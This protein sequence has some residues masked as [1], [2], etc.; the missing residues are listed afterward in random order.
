ME[1]R[2]VLVDMSSETVT[3]SRVAILGGTGAL[4]FGLAKRLAAAGVPIVIGSRDA[5]R[6]A[7]AAKRLLED[8]PDAD[9]D[10]LT[11]PEAVSAADRLVVLAVPL[12]SQVATLK[13]VAEQLTEAHIVMDTTVP[14]AP[15]VGGRPT[16]TVGLWAGSAAQQAGANVPRGVGVVSGLHTLSAASLEDLSA[17]LDESTLICGDRKEHKDYVIDLLR[18]IEG[19]HVVDA[20]RLEMSRHVE[21]I[22]PLLIGI[23]I[24]YKTHSGI[25]IT[26]V[27]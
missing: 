19:L 22:T 1:A 25:R 6:A 23:N 26:G 9:V 17:Q 16:Q 15:A 4:G 12:A 20:G 2:L 7:E 14:L 24:R 10:D 8:V 13:S 5:Q 3:I 21:S 11:N 27:E 18:R